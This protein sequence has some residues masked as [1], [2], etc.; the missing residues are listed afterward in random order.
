MAMKFKVGDKVRFVGDK[1]S[2]GGKEKYFGKT[3]VISYVYKNSRYPYSFN[4]EGSIF[5]WRDTELVLVDDSKIIITT[6]GTTTLARLY[7]DNKV[8]KSA[9]AK[10]CPEDTFDFKV[11]AEIAFNRLVGKP[12]G[13]V[14]NCEWRVVNRKPR[15]GDYIRLKIENFSFNNVGDVLKIDKVSDTYVSVLGKNHPRDTKF[16]YTLWNYTLSTFDVVEKVTKEET[17]HKYKPGDKVKV[18]KNTCCHNRR[19]GD[20]VTLSEPYLLPFVK[21]SAWLIN[22]GACYVT[23]N[24]I[25]PYVELEEKKNN[26]QFK[27][28]DY[29]KII[30]N[31]SGH[32]FE[33]GTI[34]KLIK[35]KYNYKAYDEE[36]EYWF[37]GDADLES[38]VKP[39]TIDGFK[40]GDRVNYHGYNG[41]VICLADSDRANIGVEFDIYKPYNHSCDNHPLIDGKPG[42]TKRCAWLYSATLNH[43]EV[44]KVP[45]YYNGKVVCVGTADGYGHDSFTVGKVY[46]IVDGKF[47]D[48]FG[49]TRP[50]TNVRVTKVEDL[51][52][53]Y[54]KDW[55]YH[56]IPLVED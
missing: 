6:D 22:E 18:V 39:I 40:V 4:G 14:A 41:T 47:K 25:E 5:V 8:V 52:T 31:N 45:K 23:E 9:E 53:G 30:A 7:E 44:P 2:C 19:I 56:F 48:K 34:V 1:K 16:D 29:A 13:E 17:K 36:G 51:N 37:V 12:I 20:V 35:Y 21:S 43:G 50:C 49:R 24:D 54:F 38:Y 15:V 10:C 26:I 32:R 27:S 55:V 46:E 42:T 11:G 3:A 33:I 28:G